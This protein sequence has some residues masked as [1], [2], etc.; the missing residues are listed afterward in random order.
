MAE[1]ESRWAT[2][3][4]LRV[5]ARVA[6]GGSGR[7]ALVFVHGLGV[8]GRYMVPTAARLAS[9]FPV[10]VPDLPGFG[11]SA[12][13]A[14]VLTV[15]EL[16]GVLGEW[17]DEAALERPTLVGNSLGCQVA[18]ELAVRRLERVRAA[19]LAGPTVD[20]HARSAPRQVLRL[21]IDSLRE[22]PS[23]VPLIARDYLSAGVLRTA[24]TAREALRDRIELKL[25]RLSRP[26]LVVRGSR[27][28]LVSARWA[29]EVTRLLPDGRLIVIPGAAHAVSYNAPEALA[30]AITS[31]LANRA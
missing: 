3:N 26:T 17:I 20:G 15:A 10:Y 14:H 24:L 5:H 12:R 7:P 28:A 8:S 4:G 21:L 18:V 1:L 6:S 23:L 19:V 30:Q 31:F 9:E 13:P 11:R 16:A 2:V 29:K 25:P 22:P 27:D